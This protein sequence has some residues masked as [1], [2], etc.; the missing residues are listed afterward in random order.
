[1]LLLRSDANRISKET[2]LN[3]NEF[4]EEITTGSEPYVYEMKKTETG[5]CFFLK[6]NLC[7]IYNIRPLICRFYPFPL[8]YLGKNK[9]YFSYTKRCPGIGKGTKLKKVFF[10]NLFSEMLGAMEENIQERSP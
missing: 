1:M 6:N 3:K 9:Y 7:S 10:E 2:L 5:S 4:A 8:G